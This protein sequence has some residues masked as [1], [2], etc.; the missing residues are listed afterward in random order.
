MTCKDT[1]DPDTLTILGGECSVCYL[2]EK[3]SES[4]PVVDKKTSKSKESYIAFK[5]GS[6]KRSRHKKEL[7]S[8]KSKITDHERELEKLSESIAVK[9][10]R[11]DWE[12]LHQASLQKKELENSILELYAHLE[13]LEK[14]SFD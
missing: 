9:I 14:L 4:A 2:K 6:K 1:L 7:L 5:E 8:V 11:N 13:Q 12:Q 10:P 3:L